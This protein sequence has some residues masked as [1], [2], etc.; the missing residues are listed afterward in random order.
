MVTALGAANL[1]SG[2]LLIPPTPVLNQRFQG[3]VGLSRSHTPKLERPKEKTENPEVVRIAEHVMDPPV[4]SCD[5]PT[6]CSSVRNVQLLLKVQAAVPP[7][8]EGAGGRVRPMER[9][10]FART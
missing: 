2:L 9:G 1:R 7:A 5:L 4:L 8:L 10:G 6:G 3:S